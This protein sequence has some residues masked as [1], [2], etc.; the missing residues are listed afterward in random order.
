MKISTAQRLIDKTMA[1]GMVVFVGL[2]ACGTT[3]YSQ[4]VSSSESAARSDP[5]SSLQEIIVTAEKRSTNI[6]DTPIAM[7]AFAGED[8]RRAAINDVSGLTRLAPDLQLMQT[9]RTLQLSIRGVTSL[10]ISSSSDPALTVSLD[11]EYIN[12][13]TAINAALFDLERVEVLRGPQGTLYGRNSTA[14]ALNLV[15]AKPV[16]SEFEGYVTAGY[17]N[18]DAK[19]GEAAFNLPIGDK[20]AVRVSLFHDDHSGY[21]DNHPAIDGDNANTSAARI[22]MLAQPTDRL[23]AYVAGEF[24]DVNEAQVA[25]YGVPINGSTP[26]LVPYTNPNNPAQSSFI[27]SQSTFIYDPSRF[28]LATNGSFQSHQYAIRGRLD[29]DFGFA[30]L[31][32]VAGNRY[33]RSSDVQENDGLPADGG[34]H[35]FE[36]N[37]NLD[38]HTQSHE[39]RLSSNKSSPLIWQAGAFFFR[40]TQN[41]VQA[42]YSPNFQ[43]PPL[44]AA[45]TYVNTFYRPDLKDTSPAAFGQMTIPVIDDTLSVTAGIRYT[46]DKKSGTFYACP[47][48]FGNYLI[49]NVTA[50]PGFNCAGVA[51]TPQRFSGSKVT[52]STGI[53]WHP[54][55]GHLVYGKV[56]SGYKAGGFDNAGSFNPESLVAYEIG[57]K[58]EFLDRKLQFNADVFYY[59]YTNQQ[60]QV[61]VDENIGFTTQNAGASRIYGLETDTHYQLTAIDRLN[62]TANYLNARFTK[63]EGSYG[64][65]SGISYPAD[66]SGHQ[67]PLAPRFVFSLGYDHTFSL[68]DSGTLTADGV[69]RYT[70]SYFLSVDNWASDRV[71]GF[72]R[73][74][75]GLE[76][77][78]PNKSLSVRGYVHNLENKI[79]RTDALYSSPPGEYVFEFSDPRTY[80]AQV[81][82][83]F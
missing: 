49:G 35:F 66:L 55:P 76:Y 23:T 59:D 33:I 21:R 15:A 69:V 48:N 54:A 75:L 43:I 80:G 78:S 22:S 77:R 16:L 41:V 18:F 57:S 52:W 70:T 68:G 8:I 28:P 81:T 10:D 32:Y 53:D 79:V 56:S 63:Y 27:P 83:K 64:N 37:P 60:V 14:G 29:Y 9:D 50:L 58:N 39:L 5:E 61:F 72:S 4:S 40:E 24:V 36:N 30:N 34:I 47:F 12:S 74:E 51:V 67:P 19:H 11:G 1:A 71:A 44:P 65:L 73:T 82:K 3:A 20:V 7:D 46:S 38:S 25:Q 45:G 13:G 42:L 17:G 6:Q 26:G 31:T 2:A 62:L